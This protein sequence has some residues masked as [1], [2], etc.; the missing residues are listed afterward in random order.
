[1]LERSADSVGVQV[2]QY[3]MIIV[4]RDEAFFRC[5]LDA[6]PIMEPVYGTQEH[7]KL[8][9]P[10]LYL[11]GIKARKDADKPEAGLSAIHTQCNE[12]GHSREE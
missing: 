12:E 5:V 1:M 4:F 2:G 9:F 10:G 11:A 8:A 6:N 3:D 7:E